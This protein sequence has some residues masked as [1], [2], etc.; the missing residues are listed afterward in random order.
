MNGWED[1]ALKGVSSFLS[2]WEEMMDK[3][4]GA[5]VAILI[6]LIFAWALK[7]DDDR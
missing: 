2:K 5:I 4:I 6:V 1:G 3:I 7:A